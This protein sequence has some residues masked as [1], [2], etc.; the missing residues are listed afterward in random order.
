M[1]TCNNAHLSFLI[2][3]L[4]LN[5]KITTGSIINVEH[6]KD[7]CSNCTDEDI[8]NALNCF[9]SYHLVNKATVYKC[10][11]NIHTFIPTDNEL[12]NGYL[13]HKCIE[14][15]I[16]EDETFISPNEFID[17]KESVTYR[18]TNFS[19]QEI[20]TARSY[21]ISNDFNKAV[22]TIY[23]AYNEE[24]KDIKDTKTLAEKIAPYISSVAGSATVVEKILPAVEMLL[25][26]I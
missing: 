25:K 17:Y 3:N 23:K 26:H 24:F 20:W 2:S 22:S 8:I 13:C 15:G 18:A 21:Y 12:K 7:F 1:K 14:A 10:K 5:G 11:D 16:D 9:N 19:D 6:I 4:I